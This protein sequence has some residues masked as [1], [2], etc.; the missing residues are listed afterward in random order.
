MRPW[1]I[2][3]VDDAIYFKL[4]NESVYIS[5]IFSFTPCKGE[6]K[7]RCFE[8]SRDKEKYVL[9]SKGMAYEDQL[10]ALPC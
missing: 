2:G 8:E 1:E 3:E 9:V 6:E 7:S 5:F 4:V 10:A